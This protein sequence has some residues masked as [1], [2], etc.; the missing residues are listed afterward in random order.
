MYQKLYEKG[1]ELLERVGLT[2]VMN[3]VL[4]GLIIIDGNGIIKAFNPAAETIFGYTAQDV[5]GKNVKA[6]MPEPYHS[7]H[8]GYL[9]NYKTTH[10]PKVIGIGR[11]VVGKRKNGEHFPMELGVNEMI[12]DGTLMFVG[13]VR[14]ISERKRAEKAIDQHISALQRSNQALDDFAYIAS[15]D[16]KEPLRGLSNNALFLKE[17]YGTSL[18]DDALQRIDRIIYLSERMEQLVNDLL[19]FSRIT[20]QELAIQ[21]TVIADVIHDILNTIESTLHEQNVEVTV[22]D[23]LPTIVCDRIRI[24]EVF[25]NLI[26]NAIK[27]NDKPFK[28]I[29]IGYLEKDEAFFVKDNGIGIKESFYNEVFR[30][31]KR[32]NE[33]N[34]EAKGSGVGL[35]FVKRIVDRH[36]GNIWI[37]STYGEGTTFY[38]TI[39]QDSLELL[40]KQKIGA[41]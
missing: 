22:Q 35:T 17:D 16:L 18:T 33:E 41:K 40:S 24:G 23:T 36:N 29:E 19:Y 32:L 14:D 8:D 1:R 7:E 28:T 34:D 30:L 6:L 11:E 20:N 26:T 9:H 21:E 4:D 27:Y 2:T 37:E 12:A 15:H 31:F 10:V 3:T 5:I 13:T 39:P 38:F 25:R